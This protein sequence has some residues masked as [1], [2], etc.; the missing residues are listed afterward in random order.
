M[1]T[2]AIIML[3]IGAVGLWGGLVFAIINYNLA[4][5]RQNSE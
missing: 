3:I 4:S 2:S 5:R 1:D